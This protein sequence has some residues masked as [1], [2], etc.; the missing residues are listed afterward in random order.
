MV[1]VVP[2]LTVVVGCPGSGKT[3][4]LLHLKEEGLIQEHLE[5]YL[6]KLLD[7]EQNLRLLKQ[8]LQMGCRIGICGQSFREVYRRRLLEMGLEHVS[9]LKI[10]WVFFELNPKA[11]LENII[12]EGLAGRGLSK[13]RVLSVLDIA[14][15]SAYNFPRRAKILPVVGRE[16]TPHDLARFFREIDFGRARKDVERK[17]RRYLGTDSSS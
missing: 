2:Q 11:C 14:E 1:A 6:E 13:E 9:G 3:R 8:S 15:N 12:K 10:E 16:V 4:Y 5:D 7:L 17:I